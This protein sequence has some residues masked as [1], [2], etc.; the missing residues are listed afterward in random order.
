MTTVIERDTIEIK[1][2]K[3]INIV[4]SLTLKLNLKIEMIMEKDSIQLKL[5]IMRNLCQIELKH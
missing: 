3:L 2:K 1:Y 4:I 5:T